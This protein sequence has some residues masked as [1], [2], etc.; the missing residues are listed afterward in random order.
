M[1]PV[2]RS[3]V[4]RGTIVSVNQGDQPNWDTGTPGPVQEL[5]SR[6]NVVGYNT[7]TG[8]APTTR[9]TI[10]HHTNN[11]TAEEMAQNGYP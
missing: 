11:M 5:Q 4:Q 1:R 10:I 2:R 6:P 9:E 3:D 8:Y 7:I